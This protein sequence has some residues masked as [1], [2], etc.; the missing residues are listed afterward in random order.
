MDSS[1]SA[2]SSA[3]YSDGSNFGAYE[4][5]TIIAGLRFN[6]P[7]YKGARV[8]SNKALK[9]SK[10]KQSIETL[11][12]VEK[13]VS[14]DVK[15]SFSKLK[16]SL[17]MVDALKQANVSTKLQLEASKLGLEVGVRTAIDVLNSEQQMSDVNNQLFSAIVDSIIS[18]A[19]LKY[20]AGVLT[21]S[22][23]KKINGLLR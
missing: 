12:N 14:Y 4:S 11:N 2:F 21:L 22:D 17:A 8:L 15:K 3:I 19:Q 1:L 5:T 20:H 23:L 16:S 18:H 9:N 6:L 13:K 7:L 10:L